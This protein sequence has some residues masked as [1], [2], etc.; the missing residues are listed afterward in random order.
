MNNEPWKKKGL[1]DNEIITLTA[2]DN[3]QQVNSRWGIMERRKKS[4]RDQVP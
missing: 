4:D 2:D 1:S 3:E